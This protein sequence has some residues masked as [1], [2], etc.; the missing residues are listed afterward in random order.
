MPGIAVSMR[1]WQQASAMVLGA[2][3]LTDELTDEE[4]RPLLAW[5][6]E[7]AKAAADELALRDQVMAAM[8]AE[9][10]RSMLADKLTPLRRTMKVINGLA[11]D[12]RSLSPQALFE[13]LKYVVELAG[14]L[15]HPPSLTDPQ[16]PLAE[17]SAQQADLDN[18][19][20]VQAILALLG[21]PSPTGV[22]TGAQVIE[23][24]EKGDE[25]SRANEEHE[26]P[27]SGGCRDP[28]RPDDLGP[29]SVADHGDPGPGPV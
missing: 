5:G 2:S 22:D 4:A 6:L 28:D 10:V 8:P 1:L 21:S 26:A 7:Q 11:A 29:V 27:G 20:F 13:E 9:D 23:A 24:G 18:A 16:V 12:R 14:G 25:R 15:P 3:S 19:A 17:L